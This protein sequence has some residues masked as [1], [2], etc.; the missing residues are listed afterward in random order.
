MKFPNPSAL[1]QN[2]VA[3]CWVEKCLHYQVVVSQPSSSH[4]NQTQDKV[5]NG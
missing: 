5:D 4:L 3:F 1:K 2:Y